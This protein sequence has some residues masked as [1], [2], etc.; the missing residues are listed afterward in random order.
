MLLNNNMKC[1]ITN[2][3]VINENIDNINIIL[4]NNKKIKINLKKRYYG[5]YQDLDITIVDIEDVNEII[6]NLEFLDYDLNY[7]KGYNQYINIDL[8]TL[9]YPKNE[10]EVAS[11]KIIKIINNNE[12]IYTIDTDYGSSGCPIILSNT[13]KV[14]GIHKAGD[15]N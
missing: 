14:I 10:I 7:I 5:F 11:G 13:L 1:L 12:F 3:H 15:K 6:K 8:F 9:E 4:Y 2:Y